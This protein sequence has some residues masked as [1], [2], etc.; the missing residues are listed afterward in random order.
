MDWNE[1]SPV[2]GLQG[3]SSLLVKG[4]IAHGISPFHISLEIRKHS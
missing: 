2:L 1:V 4:E 3:T